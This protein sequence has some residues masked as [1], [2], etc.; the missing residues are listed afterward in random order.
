M[1]WKKNGKT[2]AGRKPDH[3]KPVPEEKKTADANQMLL[4]IITPP[5]L[6]ITDTSANLGENYGKIYC[7]SRYPSEG[8]D[9]GWLAPLCS[10]EGTATVIEYRN[11]ESANIISVYNKRIG[12]M[13]SNR[14]LAK[15]ESERQQYDKGI[16]DLEDMIHRLSVLNEPVGYVNIMLHI[17]DSDREEL[18]NRVKRVSGMAA[19]CGCSLMLLKYKQK[20]ALRCMAPYGMPDQMVANMGE[21]N[22]PIST[23]VG[24]FPMASSGIND[25]EGFF[26]GKTDTGSLILLNMWLRNR[27]RVN[28]NWWIQGMPG[29]GKSTFVK[30][31]FLKEYACGTRIVI[32]DPEREYQS[33]ARHPDIRGE[34]IDCS[35]GETGRIN[36]LQIR[37]SPRVTAEDLDNGEDMGQYMGFDGDRGLSDMALYIQ[38]LRVF[39]QSYFGPENFDAG[40]RAELERCLIDTYSK[41]G[42][43]WETDVDA[44]KPEEFP[45]LKDLYRTAGERRKKAESEYSR[46]IC[47]RLLDLLY[48]VAE[49]ADQFM[50]NGPTTLSPR[51]AFVVLDTSGLLDMDARVKNAQFHNINTWA[52]GYASANREEKVLYDVDEGYLFVDPD[53]PETMKFL[54]NFS[55]RD[56]KYEAGLAFVT[57]SV[58]DVLDEKVKRMGQ[59]LIDNACYKF[60]MGGDGKN[61]EETSRLFRL[62]EQEENILSGKNRGQGILIAGSVRVNARIIVREQFLQLFGSGGGR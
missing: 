46:G 61:L 54:R 40:I 12:E 32:N 28:S 29:L 1:L 26:I 5:G 51:T 20:E 45:V 25:P 24:G 50:W 8:V 43:T 11:T 59:A 31:L 3:G 56:R 4:N 38:S 17:Q 57:H 10:L 30:L 7:I 42:I 47:D 27:D 52:W 6:D 36:P 13:K 18:K 22:M 41:A 55:K 21:R 35:G 60:L 48:P 15:Q 34:I 23:F 62:T 33:M 39:F 16:R 44:L 9:Y 53:N 58:V 49:G 14:E 19:V 37:K 2:A